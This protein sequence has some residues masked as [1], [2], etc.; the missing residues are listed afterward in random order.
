MFQESLELWRLI[1]TWCIAN[2]SPETEKMLKEGS[3]VTW[4]AVSSLARVKYLTFAFRSG[5]A[6]VRSV[7]NSLRKVPPYDLAFI[8]KYI[9][10]ERS[11]AKVDDARVTAAYEDAVLHF[12]TR[13]VDLWL[14][15]LEYKR[16]R[17]DAVNTVSQVYWRAMKQLDA[18]SASQFA[19]RV[20]LLNIKVADDDITA[21]DIE[22]E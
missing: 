8:L 13:H 3:Q 7:Y 5:L 20:C 9:E 1:L 2:E 17:A 4:L 10:C 11:A 6:K 22:M 12:G 14:A 19:Q 15:Y 18:E 21:D 16:E